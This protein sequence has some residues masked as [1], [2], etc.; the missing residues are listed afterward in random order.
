M[1][2][3]APDLDLGRVFDAEAFVRHAGSIVG[4]LDRISHLAS[5]VARAT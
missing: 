4:R 3:A 1:A 2:E 5:S